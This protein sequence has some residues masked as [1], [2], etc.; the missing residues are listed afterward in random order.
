MA[1]W[2]LELTGIKGSDLSDSQREAIAHWIVEGYVAGKI[3]EDE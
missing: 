3:E 2:E 1:W